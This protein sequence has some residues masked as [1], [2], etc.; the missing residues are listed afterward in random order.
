MEQFTRL[1]TRAWLWGFAFFGL[2]IAL[3]IAKNWVDDHLILTACANA[4]EALGAYFQ[5]LGFRRALGRNER[6]SPPVVLFVVVANLVLG[7]TLVVAHTRDL[8]R[9]GEDVF[10]LTFLA[11]MCREVWTARQKIDLGQ[12]WFVFAAVLAMALFYAVS[13]VGTATQLATG[14]PL[15]F[16]ADP[17]DLLG[18][19][20]WL[21]ALGLLAMV[22]NLL[23]V[24]LL[25][26]ERTTM[27]TDSE[28]HR[29]QL[30]R[31]NTELKRFQT[32]I[33]KTLAQLLESRTEDTAAHVQRVAKLTRSTLAQM[34]YDEAFC[35]LVSEASTLHDVGKIGIPDAILKKKDKLTSDE[36][37]VMQ[38]HAQFGRELFCESDVPFFRL[39]AR[40]AGEHHE[41]WDGS[42][43]PL[44]KKGNE[45]CLEARVVA[46]ADTYDALISTRSYKESWTREAALTYLRSE[47]GTRFDPVVVSAFVAGLSA[48]SP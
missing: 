12:R 10:N 15:K 28:D 32:Q 35:T 47:A 7:T 16:L 38:N 36:R 5:Y 2:G 29:I 42:G 21:V 20:E 40:I 6:V 17:L 30:R 39:A 34:G 11:L 3:V 14:H 23:V 1:A 9:L 22:E 37:A 26:G 4:L 25:T 8:A 44:G 46:V 27:L 33:L 48:V 41:H 43:Y 19:V 13:A 31:L 45:I 24:G 18:P